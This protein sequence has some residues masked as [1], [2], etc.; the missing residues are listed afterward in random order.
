MPVIHGARRHANGMREPWWRRANPRPY[1]RRL[2][3][4]IRRH[5]TP[6]FKSQRARDD[7]GDGGDGDDDDDGG[8]SR[9]KRSAPPPS[10]APTDDMA[11]DVT[12]S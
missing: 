11:R 9:E 1:K 12:T 3:R 8:H 5:V 10:L 7:G 4:A 2:S 6:R